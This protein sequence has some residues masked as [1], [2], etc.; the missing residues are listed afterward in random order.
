[1]TVYSIFTSVYYAASKQRSYFLSSLFQYYDDFLSS[2][3][4]YQNIIKVVHISVT[5]VQNFFIAQMLFCKLFIKIKVFQGTRRAR[6]LRW[7]RKKSKMLNTDQKLTS[8]CRS[9]NRCVQQL[10]HYTYIPDVTMYRKKHSW[11][12]PPKILNCDTNNLT[13]L[14]LHHTFKR[15][16]SVHF[17][18]SEDVRNFNRDLP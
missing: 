11:R 1:M 8:T 9:F 6:I 18:C 13:E 14:V 2:C 12:D 7:L 3:T 16:A 5:T 17:S 10:T 4:W 15:T